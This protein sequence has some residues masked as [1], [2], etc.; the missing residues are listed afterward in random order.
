M[1]ETI[2]AKQIIETAN[3]K[4]KV[5]SITVEVGDLAHLPANEKREVLENMTDWK[6][7][8]I[9]KKATV[10][11]SCGYEGEPLIL[12]KGHDSTIFQCPKCKAI[13]EILDGK[14]ITLKEVEVE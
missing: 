4:G 11:C 1:H 10:K 6:I 8:I 5:K 7:N 2:I 3:S 9:E 14:D 12:E 13:P